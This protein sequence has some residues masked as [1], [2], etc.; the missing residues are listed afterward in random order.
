MSDRP[1]SRP[2]IRRTMRI[3]TTLML[4]AAAIVGASAAAWPRI[5]P[6]AVPAVPAVARP[7][8]RGRSRVA[9]PAAATPRPHGQAAAPANADG[10]AADAADQ[11]DS[12][13]STPTRPGAG[14]QEQRRRHDR[15]HRRQGNDADSIVATVNDES[16]SDYELR[17]RVALYLA[18]NGINQQLTAEQRNRIRGQILEEL[19]DEKIQLQ[20]AVKKQITVSPVEVD[21][22]LNGMMARTITSPSSSC[23]RT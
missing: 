14:S 11:P 4:G 15:R 20:E 22:R 8:R 17:Q 5:R 23:A 10:R 21:K 12:Q 19:E 9:K 18:L 2:K 3:A 13:R 7:S 1:C 6:Q 16:I